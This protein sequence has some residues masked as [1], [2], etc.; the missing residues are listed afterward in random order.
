MT[1]VTSTPRPSFCA[2]PEFRHLEA[3]I[4]ADWV[5]GQQQ[6]NGRADHLRLFGGYH[7]R[8]PGSDYDWH[9]R[10]RG[11]DPQ[12]PSVSLQ[13]TLAGEGRFHDLITGI[14]YACTPGTLFVAVIPSDH[15]YWLPTQ[16]DGWRFAWIDLVLPAAVERILAAVRQV[17]PVIPAAPHG[18]C[19]AALLALLDLARGVRGADDQM[20]DRALMEV[21]WTFAA[22]ARAA[23]PLAANRRRLLALVDEV[24][25]K[26][27]APRVV[28]IARRAGLTRAAFTRSFTA[29]V[30]EP[31]AQHLLNRRLS[32]ARQ[33]LVN[34]SAD[35]T[36][37][38][39]ACG[40]ADAT[41]LG[42]AFR[43]RFHLTPGRWRALG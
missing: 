10:R 23:D 25:A 2:R 15:R 17:A 35:L 42:K 3:R 33:M 14:E 32:R 18:P 36:A 8:L 38:A 6:A 9:G 20:L 22:A 28:D 5:L 43:R 30:G 37:V 7:E 16:S 12:R 40:F 29:A 39:A 19:V 1:I 4:A 27:P 24:L 41:H 31:P 26:D 34:S 13:Y 21:A 11:G